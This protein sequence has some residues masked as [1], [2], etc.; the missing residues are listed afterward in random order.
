M[1]KNIVNAIVEQMEKENLL[2]IE[3]KEY[4]T[5]S[6]AMIIEKWITII[7]VLFV[8]GIFKHTVQMMLFLFFFLLLRK[9]TGGYHASSFLHCYIETIIIS[10]VVIHMCL[11]SARY[12][13]VIYLLVICSI[14]V[15]SFIGVVNHPNLALDYVEVNESKKAARCILAIESIIIV[16]LI[17]LDVCRL[18]VCYM[19]ASIILCALL[20][21]LAKIIK[22]EVK[23]ENE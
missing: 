14:L 23:F 5:Y 10:I 3:M 1:V 8:G 9:R 11:I 21:G 20:L 16:L 22:Q 13:M 12:M 2:N 15:I 6:I 7:S 19:S 18:C 17:V 4:F